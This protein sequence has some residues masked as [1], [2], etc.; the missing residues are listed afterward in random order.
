MG[1][2]AQIPLAQMTNVVNS[3]SHHDQTIQSQTESKS[4]PNVRVNIPLPQNIGVNH[5]TGTELDPAA[6]LADPASLPLADQAADVQFKPGFNKREKTRAQPHLDGR[7]KDFRKH[8]LHKINQI[9][10]GNG[11]PHHHALNLCEGH[12]VGSVGPLTAKNHT[13]SD[14]TKRR[15]MSPHPPNLQSRSV[16]AQQMLSI[17]KPKG[18]LH[19]PGG[20]IRGI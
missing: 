20:M 13:R 8:G 19:I 12:L 11:L 6:L 1:V 9:G 14:E 5:A 3:I 2:K 10:D 18:V 16:G 17:L 15:G 7:T 4:A